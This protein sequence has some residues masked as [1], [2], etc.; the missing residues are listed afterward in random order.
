[1]VV[2]KF[3]PEPLKACF[4]DETPEAIQN[5]VNGLIDSYNERFQGDKTFDADEWVS[6]IPASRLVDFDAL[7]RLGASTFTF[8]D[9]VPRTTPQTR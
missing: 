1:L 4:N 8:G 6:K 3:G 9:A 5:F 2:D 7:T